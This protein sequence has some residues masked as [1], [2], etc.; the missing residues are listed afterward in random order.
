MKEIIRLESV[1]KL[2]GERRAI[3]GVSLLVNEN[4]HVLVKGAPGSG[5]ST[6]MKLIA[7]MERPSAGEVHV[8]G[9]ALHGTDPDTSSVFRNR[10]IGVVLEDPGLMPEL[11]LLENAALPLAVRGASVLKREKAAFEILKALGLSHA[12]HTRPEKVSVYEA[13]VASLAR[14]LAGQPKILLMDEP[15][16]RLSKGEAEK[17]GGILSAL[18]EFGDYT[19]LSFSAEED[20]IL[21]TGK[22]IVLDH[23]TIKEDKS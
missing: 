10:Y 2:Y 14:A 19:I 12:A 23:G 15:V 9:K 13:Q 17:L 20:G 22:R 11:S 8:L 5:K 18:P 1:I 4:E 16:A 3:N 6:L 7:G 21:N